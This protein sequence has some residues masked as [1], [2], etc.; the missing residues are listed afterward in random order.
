MWHFSPERQQ[1]DHRRRAEL[2]DLGWTL[3]VYT[4]R[5]IVGEPAPVGREIVATHSRLSQRSV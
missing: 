4:W 3:R 5:D 2:Q 1:R